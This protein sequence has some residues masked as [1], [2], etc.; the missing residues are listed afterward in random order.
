MDLKCLRAAIIDA[1]ETLLGGRYV[2]RNSSLGPLYYAREGEAD[3][4]AFMGILDV[5]VFI[6]I[7]GI[8]VGE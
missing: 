7:F 4:I 3:E 5:R 2:I 8:V 1:I 6:F